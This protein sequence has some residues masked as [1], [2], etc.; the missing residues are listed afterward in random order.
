MFAATVIA[1]GGEHGS[2]PTAPTS[3]TPKAMAMAIDGLRSPLVV[4]E[5]VQL[6]ATVSYADGSNRDVTRDAEWTSTDVAIVTANGLLT[7]VK[8]GYGGLHVV[9]RP[10]E[11]GKLV[12]F[13]VT[14]APPS[15]PAIRGIVHETSPRPGLALAAVRVEIANGPYAG[16]ATTTDYDGYF[17]FFG[18][19]G[20]AF[21]LVASKRGYESTRYRIGDLPRDHAPDIL[22]AGQFRLATHRMEGTFAPECYQNVTA[23]L[24]RS[25]YF[26][27]GRDGV[28][29]V[30]RRVNTEEDSAHIFVG[31]TPLEPDR[32][33]LPIQQYAVVA[34]ER[35]ELRLIAN[36]CRPV[37]PMDGSYWV[38]VTWP[39]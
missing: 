24:T 8:P 9:Y 15:V 21:D 27:P 23:I 17:Q 18:I 20:G 34:G 25:F 13:L 31:S 29:T 16:Q 28:A 4:G 35:H 36:T 22:I 3:A 39:Q 12:E 30:E 7:A 19:Q 11:I 26:T 32:R 5:S 2:P 37:P 38:V 1:C 10:A 33:F 14:P 6:T